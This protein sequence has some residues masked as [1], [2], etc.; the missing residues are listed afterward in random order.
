MRLKE[1]KE[2]IE[3]RIADDKAKIEALNN[4]VI[5]KKKDGSDFVNLGKAIEGGC[6]VKELDGDYHISVMYHGASYGT[7][8]IPCYGYM[9]ELPEGDPRKER[10]YNYSTTYKLNCNEI[11]IKIEEE[12]RKAQKEI[13]DLEKFKTDIDNIYNKLIDEAREINNEL[14]T[15]S[16]FKHE[17]TEGVINM[18]RFGWE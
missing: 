6:V 14:N 2:G 9:R 4:V 10:I 15:I 11:K 12:I 7:C 1:I 18:I 3:T 17:I 16:F 8:C 5:K 13:E